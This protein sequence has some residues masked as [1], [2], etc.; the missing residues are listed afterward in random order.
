MTGDT[1]QSIAKSLSK[2]NLVVPSVLAIVAISAGIYFVSGRNKVDCSSSGAIDAVTKVVSDHGGL[3]APLA[4][5]F[6]GNDEGSSL[7]T[8]G[9]DFYQSEDFKRLASERDNL[10]KVRHEAVVKCFD[11]S[12]H[13]EE[14]RI[15][16]RD[17]ICDSKESNGPNLQSILEDEHASYQTEAEAAVGHNKAYRYFYDYAQKSIYPINEKINGLQDQIKKAEQAYNQS[18]S[19]RRSANQGKWAEMAKDIKYTLETIVTTGKDPQTGSVAC[20]ATL[21][22]SLSGKSANQEIGYSIE[23]SSDGNLVATVYGLNT[24]LV[25]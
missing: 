11:D 7:K 20:K 14:F 3:Q 21:I 2:R 13:P 22:A 24:Y 18:Q 19:D 10:E 9:G 25:P 23:K 15:G 12:L 16:G 6:R 17:Q 8:G 1:S 5:Q 4:D